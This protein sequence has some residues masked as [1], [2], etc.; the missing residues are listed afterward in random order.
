MGLAGYMKLGP[1][2]LPLMMLVSGCLGDDAPVDSA[3]IGDLNEE[4]VLREEFAF[5]GQDIAQADGLFFYA[6]NGV[7][8][9]EFSVDENAT[10]LLVEAVWTCTLELCPMD[11]WVYDEDSEQSGSTSGDLSARLVMDEPHRDTWYA[12]LAASPGS[13]HANVQADFRV[14][15]F[16]DG[17]VPDGYTA[18]E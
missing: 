17:P 14:T 16:Y 11:L 12:V 15:V 2:A 8:G 9:G 18:F 13:A 3:E 6:Y 1:L 7:A 5:Q 10:A 4:P